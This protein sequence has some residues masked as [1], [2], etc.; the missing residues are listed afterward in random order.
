MSDDKDAQG[1]ETDEAPASAFF[2][3]A[4][5]FFSEVLQAIQGDNVLRLAWAVE[6][7]LFVILALMIWFGDLTGNQRFIF[8]LVIIASVVFMFVFSARRTHGATSAD[9]R[10]DIMAQAEKC[11]GLLDAIGRA[12]VRVLQR[13][14]SEGGA[15]AT[16]LADK[17][18]RVCHVLVVRG[19][20][21]SPAV[22]AYFDVISAEP[23]VHTV[24]QSKWLLGE[25]LDDYRRRIESASPPPW[26]HDKLELLI[27]RSVTQP[28]LSPEALGTAVA[29]AIAHAER[30]LRRH[31]RSRQQTEA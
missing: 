28:D 5:G 24:C 15:W 2:E 31:R 11:L 16:L 30:T 19:K 4:F 13:G 27:R 6:V 3:K 1:P 17:Y 29:A 18:N 26:D 8:A 9:S 10:A 21:G 14:R 22:D 25:A 12:N 7:L 20:E 23:A